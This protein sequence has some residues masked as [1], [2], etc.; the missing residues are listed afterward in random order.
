MMNYFRFWKFWQRK[1]DHDLAKASILFR[2][3]YSP[4]SIHIRH[5][6][7]LRFLEIHFPIKGHID[8]SLRFLK[9]IAFCLDELRGLGFYQEKM[10]I[11][12]PCNDCIEPS[13]LARFYYLGVRVISGLKIYIGL[14]KKFMSFYNYYNFNSHFLNTC[15]KWCHHRAPI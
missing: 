3:L 4:V 14:E 5:F 7:S 6:V 11:W 8:F 1:G 2:I 13:L 15:K 9:G 12:Y 10:W